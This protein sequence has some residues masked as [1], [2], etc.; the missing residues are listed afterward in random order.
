M[1]TPLFHLFHYAHVNGA[2]VGSMFLRKPLC[3]VCSS[4]MSTLA[5]FFVQLNA[6]PFTCFTDMSVMSL[7]VLTCVFY[8]GVPESSK[9]IGALLLKG[10]SGG[11]AFRRSWCSYAFLAPHPPWCSSF[12]FFV[13]LRTP[14]QCAAFFFFFLDSWLCLWVHTFRQQSPER[15]VTHPNYQSEKKEES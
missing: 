15:G 4:V 11:C 5:Y 9:N 12:F 2:Y 14:M 8:T 1:L 3:H 13:R 6:V 10:G 7:I